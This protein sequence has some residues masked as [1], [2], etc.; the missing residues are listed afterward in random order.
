MTLELFKKTLHLLDSKER[1]FLLFVVSSACF[2][3]VLEIIS[4]A[5][6]IPVV[7]IIFNENFY[8]KYQ[9]YFEII[10]HLKEINKESLFLITITILLSLVVVKNILT[11]Y[12]NYLIQNYSFG[13]RHKYLTK[14][15]FHYLKD[16]DYLIFKSKNKSEFL[17]NL[18]NVRNLGFFILN[19]SILFTDLIILLSIVILMLFIVGKIL[20]IGLI[21]LSVFGLIYYLIFGKFLKKSSESL[22]DLEKDFYKSV[23]ESFSSF[24]EILVSNK[25]Q[26]FFNFFSNISKKSSSFLSKIT[27]I[28]SSSRNFIEIVLSVIILISLF[29]ISAFWNTDF[30][31]SIPNLIILLIALF[32]IM[33]LV[34]R[35]LSQSQKI[36]SNAAEAKN[37]IREFDYFNK[38]LKQKKDINYIG[39]KNSIEL[40]NL[41]FRYGKK[42]IL[43]NVNLKINQGKLLMLVGP[44]GA[45]KTTLLEIILGLLNPTKG[46]IL[47]DKKELNKSSKRN[48]LKAS[49]VPQIINLLDETLE[50]NITLTN[51]FFDKSRL[52]KAIHKAGLSQFLKSLSK[53]TNI[54][55]G[56][57][58]SKLSGGQKQRVGLARAFFERNDVLVLDEPTSMLD[59]KS[60][61]VFFKS[62]LKQRKNL[63][64][65]LVAHKPPKYLKPDAIFKVENKL[66]KKI[67]NF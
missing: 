31:E 32:R 37:T 19:I 42:V 8:D 51:D 28:Q 47:I 26:Y 3:A 29:Y 46:K 67:N 55:L 57:S 40:N 62:L 25:I 61:E 50:K 20:I 65:I 5:A 52:K 56:D 4:L 21:I 34:N 38:Q 17:R 53:K 64:I 13:I 14:M 48:F 6:I 36:L 11:I 33:P 30:Q 41:E 63:T 1:F 16:Y 23:N 18:G 59:K 22:Q 7:Q 60:E 2:L 35:I 49:Y 9:K 10:P 24:R 39:L 15:F 27:L 58:G 12:F 44:S 66:V 45:G 54:V 43:K